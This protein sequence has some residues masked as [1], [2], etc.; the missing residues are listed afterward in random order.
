MEGVLWGDQVDLKGE[1]R[2]WNGS[3]MAATLEFELVSLLMGIIV[4]N[5]YLQS[6]IYII[7]SSYMF[8]III[9]NT[10]PSHVAHIFPV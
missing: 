9:I 5:M 1:E 3:G 6:Q 10:Y 7:I 4:L 8:L 2:Q